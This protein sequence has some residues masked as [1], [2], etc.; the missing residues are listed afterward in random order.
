MGWTDIPRTET[1]L[2]DVYH[3]ES[4]SR[5]RPKGWVDR[6]SEGIV[7]LYS[8]LYAT[9]AQWLASQQGDTAIATDS[10]FT[11]RLLRASQIA[12]DIFAQTA[13]GRQ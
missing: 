5:P 4:A 1:L 9:Y 8:V 2:F 12:Q 6:P 11:E 13:Y 3:A 10:L 7:T